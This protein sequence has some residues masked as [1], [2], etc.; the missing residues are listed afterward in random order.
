MNAATSPVLASLSTLTI[1]D[2]ETGAVETAAL[3]PLDSIES[4]T[5]ALELPD[6]QR[7]VL[8]RALCAEVVGVDRMAPTYL[9]ASVYPTI[10]PSARALIRRGLVTKL[11]LGDGTWDLICTARGREVGYLI[12]PGI[13]RQIQSLTA[14]DTI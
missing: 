1:T 5:V 12:A 6:T 7:A 4:L 13:E 10:H 14:G 3:I 9:P 2:T 11:Q 8:Y